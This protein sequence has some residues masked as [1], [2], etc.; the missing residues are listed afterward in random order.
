[1]DVSTTAETRLSLDDHDQFSDGSNANKEISSL[2]IGNGG[3]RGSE[4]DNKFQG[5]ISAWRG[6]PLGLISAEFKLPS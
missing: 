5:A 6:E 4:N 3:S 2:T 1:M